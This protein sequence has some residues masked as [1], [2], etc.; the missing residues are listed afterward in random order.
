MPLSSGPD[1]SGA[2]QE[3]ATKNSAE[4]SI[5]KKLGFFHIDFT[6]FQRDNGRSN[7]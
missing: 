3:G 7:L 6:T 4:I 5:A 2:D 1:L